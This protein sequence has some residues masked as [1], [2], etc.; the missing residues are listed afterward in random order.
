M[1]LGCGGLRN[2]PLLFIFATD[3]SH[4]TLIGIL[5]GIRVVVKSS[6]FAI[7]AIAKVLLNLNYS[8]KYKQSR[9]ETGLF[10]FYPIQSDTIEIRPVSGDLGAFLGSPDKCTMMQKIMRYRANSRKI[11]VNKGNQ[12]KIS[13]VSQIS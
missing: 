3:N 7:F 13:H 2:P 4:K 12:R 11:R 10:C 1:E 6:G 5:L 8:W 9:C